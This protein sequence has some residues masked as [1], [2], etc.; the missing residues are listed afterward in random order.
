MPQ[1]NNI[2]GGAGTTAIGLYLGKPTIIVPFFGDQ[3]FWGSMVQHAG[4]GPS[5]I[6]HRKLTALK[7]AAGIE[8]CLSESAKEAAQRMGEKIRAEVGLS[9]VVCG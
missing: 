1:Y 5:P 7:L 8:Y 4:A 3:P 6:P 2:D 9:L